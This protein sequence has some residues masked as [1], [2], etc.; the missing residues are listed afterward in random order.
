MGL[1]VI[2]CRSALLSVCSSSLW[3]TGEKTD[4]QCLQCECNSNALEVRTLKAAHARKQIHT[5]P[6]GLS[7]IQRH[8]V[9]VLKKLRT[10]WLMYR[11][12]DN[13]PIFTVSPVLRSDCWPAVFS[14]VINTASIS[15]CS[16]HY[17]LICYQMVL[18]RTRQ[19]HRT[20]DD[21]DSPT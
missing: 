5:K 6:L 14:V 18:H 1:K 2:W 7:Q 15:S 21:T 12:Y 8:S 9:I 13:P 3:S 11:S 17:A 10:H 16:L 4:L 19:P 20:S